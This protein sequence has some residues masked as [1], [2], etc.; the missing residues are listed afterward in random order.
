M[1]NFW[2]E[3]YA[4]EQ[5][6]YG[7]EPNVFFKEWIDKQEPG[8]ILFPGEGEGR[9]AVY[10]ARKGW[11]V[12]AF[13]YSESG[14]DKALSLAEK[15]GVSLNFEVADAS[16]YESSVKFDAIVLI[17]AH[18]PPPVREAFHRKAVNWLKSGGNL[19]LEAYNKQQIKNGTGGPKAP[20]MLLD[21]ATIEHEFKGLKFLSLENETLHMEEGLY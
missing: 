8:T 17:Y 5:Y 6:A 19:V 3:R 20:E 21:N 16:E 9:N 11:N 12:Y 18:F 13:D 15:H 2:N 4:S 10:A 7:V 1:K 14:K